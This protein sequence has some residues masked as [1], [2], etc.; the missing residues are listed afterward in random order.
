MNSE[1]LKLT[2]VSELFITNFLSL[3]IN[4]YA[5]S[6]AQATHIIDISEFQILSGYI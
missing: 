1:Y 6:Y 4:S 3:D 5:Y 2:V